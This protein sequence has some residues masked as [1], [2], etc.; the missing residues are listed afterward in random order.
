MWDKRCCRA[1]WSLA[2]AL[3]AG[4]CVWRLSGCPGPPVSAGCFLVAPNFA[5]LLPGNV[6]T[7]VPPYPLHVLPGDDPSTLIDLKEF[8]FLTQSAP[9]APCNSTPLVVAVVHSAPANYINRQMIRSTW[10]TSI[11]LVF[12]V[13]ET[14]LTDV[15]AQLD[16]EVKEYGDVVQGSFFDTYRNLTYK[17]VMALKWATYHCPSAR[18]LL[19]TDDDVFVNAPKLEKFLRNELS[20]FGARR[21]ILCDVLKN[22]IVRRSFRSKWRVSPSEYPG[23]YYPSYCTGWAVVY[24]PDV[25]FKLYSEAQ[26]LPYF[27][28]DDVHVTG[29]CASQAN[30]THTH[31]GPL[32]R[33]ETQC[34]EMVDKGKLDEDFLFGLTSS[35]THIKKLWEI[36]EM[37][38]NQT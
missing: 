29:T 5:P 17:H 22:S 4:L 11:K 8:A 27:W 1:V 20:P 10:G 18:Y 3:G 7:A 33:M 19:K 13:G 35:P 9:V 15:N 28:V 26:R 14:N 16:Q 24:S 2:L 34:Q 37:S 6:S 30:I 31:I 25:V 32:L 21:L 38:S 36:L 23:R 12:M